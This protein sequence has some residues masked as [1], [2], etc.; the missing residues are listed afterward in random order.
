MNNRSDFVSVQHVISVVTEKG[1][2]E[3]LKF[4]DG[5]GLEHSAITALRLTTD[6]DGLRDQML[7]FL[8][9]QAEQNASH[10]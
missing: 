5:N 9:K 8:H 2:S 3:L 7:N 1:L 4:V 6:E 10:Q